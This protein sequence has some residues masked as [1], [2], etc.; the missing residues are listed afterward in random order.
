MSSLMDKL[1][2]M[3][4]GHEDKAD[5]GIDKSGDTLDDRTGGDHDSQIN[6]GTDSMKD[7]LDESDDSGPDDGH[8]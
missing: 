7:R 2:G 1:K 8:T 4:S 5:K 6:R 3:M